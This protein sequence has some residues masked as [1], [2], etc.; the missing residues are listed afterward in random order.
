MRIFCVGL[1]SCSLERLREHCC[2]GMSCQGVFD[3]CGK[4]NDT[5]GIVNISKGGGP[6]SSG[7]VVARI[8]VRKQSLVSA[9]LLMSA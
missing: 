8:S 3:K 1:W 5:I 9:Q 7:I 2:R 4:A 6:M